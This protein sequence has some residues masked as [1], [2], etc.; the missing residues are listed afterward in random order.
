MKFLR[1]SMMDVDKVVQV[2]QAS[3]KLWSSPPPGV[4]MLANYACLGIAFP[5][6]PPNTIVSV[7]IVEAENAEAIGA[8]SYPTALAGA[9]VWNVPVMEVPVA[10]AAEVEKKLR[11]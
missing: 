1:F 8:T 10:G 3:D 5:G 11:R 4:K 6:E 9:A 2:V 7:S